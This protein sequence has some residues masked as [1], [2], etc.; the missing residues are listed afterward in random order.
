[1]YDSGV[2]VGHSFVSKLRNQFRDRNGTFPNPEGNA[3]KL[4]VDKSFRKLYIAGTPGGRILPEYDIPR[5]IREYHP[6]VVVIDNGSNDLAN[7]APPLTVACKL[8]EVAKEIVRKFGADRVVLCASLKRGKARIPVN[9]FNE[10]VVLFNTIL[11]NFC[12]VEPAISFHQ[13]QG[14]WSSPISSWSRDQLH[15][16]TVAGFHKYKE[17]IRR[18]VLM[19]TRVSENLF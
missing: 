19:S 11:K 1:M 3:R 13:H 15:P 6:N 16:D 10:N 9:K 14:F 18:A 4:R 12:E 5:E 7:G 8:V 2:I 17:S